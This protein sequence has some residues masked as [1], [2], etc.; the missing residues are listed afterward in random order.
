MLISRSESRDF[1]PA[2]VDEVMFGDILHTKKQKSS[3]W[4]LVH[5]PGERV[6]DTFHLRAKGFYA[7]NKRYEQRNFALFGLVGD[8]R[9]VL[10]GV[11]GETYNHACVGSICSGCSYDYF[12]LKPVN[13]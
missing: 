12:F 7:Q 10:A 13:N 6:T 1:A 2:G 5:H 8:K 9:W 3:G 4:K 11:E